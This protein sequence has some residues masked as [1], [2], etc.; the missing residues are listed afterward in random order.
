MPG[1]PLS[2]D[3]LHDHLKRGTLLPAYLF[4]GPSQFLME[5]ALGLLKATLLPESVREM[6]LSVFHAEKVGGPSP[7]E[8]LDSANTLPFLHGRRMVIVRRADLFS[9]SQ[10]ERFLPYLERPSPSTCMVLL[11]EPVPFERKHLEASFIKKANTLGITVLFSEPAGQELIRWIQK[12]AEGMGLGMPQESA[13]YLKHI[14]GSQLVDLH[15]EI[16]KLSL[17]Y[18][19]CRIGV[20]EIQ[21]SAVS[22]RVFTVFELLDEI[23]AK[24]FGNSLS[25]LTRYLVGEEKDA[26]FPLLGMLNRQ[27]R[28]LWQTKA[29]I[30]KGGGPTEVSARTGVK[31]RFL[32][33]K[34]V[35]QSRQ[36]E[37]DHLREAFSLLHRADDQLKTGGSPEEV[38]R[39]YLLSLR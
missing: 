36:W 29:A 39:S 35:N 33:E 8:I 3:R 20:E 31:I 16:E 6:N 21:A 14:V 32:V 17:R 4:C 15:G 10:M 23:S 13:E 2:P 26:A 5:K 9:S 37:F 27:F 1:A 38:L 19:Q 30:E 24:R 34:L 12:T 18:G 7:G 25:I 28:L 11:W 22:S